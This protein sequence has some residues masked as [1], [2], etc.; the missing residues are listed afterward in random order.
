V[1]HAVP[2]DPVRP[3]R[4]AALVAGGVAAIE[5]VV[6]V[7][8][9]LAIAGKPL[10][11]DLGG[12][13][14]A[15]THRAVVPKHRA[16]APLPSPIPHLARARTTVLVLNGNG[17]QGAAAAEAAVVR[18]H[19]YQIGA[20]GNA[21]KTGYGRSVVM[22]R[23]GFRGEALRLAHDLRIRLVGPL[24]GLRATDLRRSQVV[25]VVGG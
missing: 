23:A 3:W 24:D 15:T 20:V 9:G 17:A 19:G 14:A 13:A 21:A 16:P 4:T 18:R 1:E 6:L 25:L 2:F 12:A 7:A 5:L 11:R 8:G 22:Y 10:W